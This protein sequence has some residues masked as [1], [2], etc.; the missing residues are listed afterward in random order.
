ML[1]EHV[2]MYIGEEA[3]LDVIRRIVFSIGI[4]NAD[5]HA[6]NWSIIYP[7]GRN[8]Q[9]APAY[10]FLS[11]I[12][13]ISDD[14]FG[15]NLAGTKSISDLDESR[16]SR[17]ASH[18]RLPRKPVLDAAHDMVERMREVWPRIK[19]DLPLSSEHRA[20]VTE[21]MNAQP[22]FSVRGGSV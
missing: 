1:T 3:A 2:A 13:Y 14:D 10:D 21:H 5:M 12:V 18:A 4:G 17:L 22:L 11:T 7:D 9:L 6:K 19:A 8:P 20:R 16:F 15:M